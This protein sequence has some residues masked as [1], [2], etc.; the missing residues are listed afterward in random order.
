MKFIILL[1][2]L[3]FLWGKAFAQK[4]FTTK[5]L[6]IYASPI[7]SINSTGVKYNG[8][9]I[10]HNAESTRYDVP[11]DY[12]Y[13]PATLTVANN[14]NIGAGLEYEFYLKNRWFLGVNADYRTAHNKIEYRYNSDALFG[15]VEPDIDFKIYNYNQKLNTFS[16]GLYG[17]KQFKLDQSKRLYEVRF[18]TSVVFNANKINEFKNVRTSIPWVN[19]GTTTYFAPFTGQYAADLNRSAI[20]VENLRTSLYFGTEGSKPLIKGTRLYGYCG[21]QG[22]IN[23]MASKSASFV[24]LYAYEGTPQNFKYKNQQ[25]DFSVA[26]TVNISLKLGL[27]LK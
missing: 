1:A 26:N 16:L 23:W 9:T 18:G 13:R 2:A 4:K 27:M 6:K 5:S 10:L 21:I 22:D 20:E 15:E 14:L 24:S 3:P 12:H 17:G 7:Y 8:S 19:D 11:E 25:A